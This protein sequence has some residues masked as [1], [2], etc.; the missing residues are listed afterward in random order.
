MSFNNILGHD[1]QIAVLRRNIHTGQLPPA[2]LFHGEEGIGKL[3]LAREFAKALNCEAGA[4]E[5]CGTCRSCRN[6]EAGCHPNVSMLALE[7]NEKTGKLRQEIVI[8]QVRAAQ[9][10]LSL[11]AVGAG[12][13]VLMVDGAHLLNANA[14]NALLKTLEEPPDESHV[15]LVTSRPGFLLPTILSRC[16]AVSFQP[17]KPGLVAGLLAKSKG[18]TEGDAFFVASMTGGRVGA[19]LEADPGELRQRRDAALGAFKAIAVAGTHGVIKQA[20]GAA[21]DKGLIEDMVLF[22]TLWFRDIMVILVGGPPALAYNTDMMGE[23]D[24]WA[25]GMTAYD[26]ESALRLLG[27]TGRALERTFNRRL[28]AEDLFF[29]LKEEALVCPAPRDGCTI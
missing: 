26:A 10:F 6:I 15:I 9:E 20:E 4:A 16:R 2:Y 21:K 3:T 5:P 23:L 27:E 29:R 18:L 8:E 11:K 25:A 17:L 12:R 22:G 19:A 1:R 24:G 14:M 28:L 13:K 7:V